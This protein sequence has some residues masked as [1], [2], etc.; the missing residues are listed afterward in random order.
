MSRVAFIGLLL[1]LLPTLLWIAWQYRARALRPVGYLE[2]R[3]R[4]APWVWLVGSGLALAIAALVLTGS[5]DKKDCQRVP[6]QYVDGKLIEA[7]CK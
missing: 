1:A 6:S 5:F 2:M 4:A 3:L 7:H